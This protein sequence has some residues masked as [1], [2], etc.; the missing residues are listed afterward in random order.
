V[1]GFITLP[2]LATGKN[3]FEF[4]IDGPNLQ[5]KSFNFYNLNP[6]HVFS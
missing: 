4:Q 6:V 2:G 5:T 3:Q 1:T